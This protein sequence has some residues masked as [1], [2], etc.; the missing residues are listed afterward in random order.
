MRMAAA[1]EI[2]PGRRHRRDL[3][4]LEALADSI[5][6]R[7]LL[8]PIVITADNLLVC[9]ERRLRACR[10]VLGWERIPA[11]VMECET[12]AG[13]FHENEIR[14]QYTPS[15]RAALVE[16]LRSQGGAGARVEQAAM[17]AGFGSRRGYYRAA[18]VVE[19][20]AAELIEAMDSGA[21]TIAAAAQMASQPAGRQRELLRMEPG[22]RRKA[23]LAARRAPQRAAAA[24]EDKERPAPQAPSADGG[25]AG[26][27]DVA[28]RGP[29]RRLGGGGG[30]RPG[31]R[32]KARKAAA[33]LTSSIEALLAALDAADANPP[34]RR[35]GKKKRPAPGDERPVVVGPPAM[36]AEE[37][38]ARWDRLTDIQRARANAKARV[39][40]AAVDLHER[41]GAL[42]REAF[43]AAARGSDWSP[44][45]LR[46]WYYGSGGRAGLA[47][48]SRHLWPLALAPAHVGRVKRAECDPVAWQ[49]FLADY[50]RPEQPPLEMSYRT[51]KR[52]AG[53]EGWTIPGSSRA[54]KRRLEREVHPAAVVLARQ[55]P[56]AVARMRPA[57]IRARGSLRALEAVNADGHVFDVFVKWPD[58]KEARPVLVAWQDIHSG[59]ILSWRL[60]RTEN[61]DGY[62]LSFADLLREYGIPA[63]V[64]VDNGRGIASKMLTGGVH[65]RYRGKVKH[66]EPVGLLTQLVGA[67]N[68]HW[69]TPYSGQS[70]PIE[71]AFR[72]LA[73]DIAKDFRLRGAYTGNAPGAKPANHGEK[74]V[75]LER[76]VE[77]A[78][79]GIRQHNAR[80]GRRGLGLDGRSFDE[81][82]AASYE[83]HR[84]EIPRP[85][86][87]QIARWL[88]A[89]LA[90]TANKDTGAV[91]LYGNRY[92]SERLAETL[93]GKPAADRKVV[94]RF[95]PDRLDRPVTVETPEG[96][97][98]GKAEAQDA[99]P[100]MSTRAARETARDKAR[101]KRNAR[102][103]L[104][105]QQRMGERDLDKL[106]DAAAKETVEAGAPSGPEKMPVAAS[107]VVCGAF[108]RGPA[109]A[110]TG[111]PA[112]VEEIDPLVSRGDD[113]ILEAAAAE[114]PRED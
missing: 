19:R 62:R 13:Q 10:D 107:K 78:A 105:I 96:R 53:E 54:L 82:F 33:R 95:D 67:E 14:K 89:A 100:V 71:R 101:L 60:D 35:H 61:T 38:S 70:K 88:P 112:A 81:A 68:I 76:F 1:S 6:E 25:A 45:T 48:Y 50:L 17:Q 113:L 86:E 20:G 23:L 37:L 93:A 57:Q 59:K 84:A 97:L 21:V 16:A 87:A 64:F 73:T 79:D 99:A 83:A 15:E 110:A 11:R 2:V 104:E 4:D 41:D 44:A 3:G 43:T 85:T 80:R 39:I 52:L 18:Q 40:G 47:E 12:A 34:K 111:A 7:G 29:D 77:V 36:S 66:D 72:D 94:A 51:L 102:Q 108:G 5:R 92:W 75:E 28:V 109:R 32:A 46:N 103:A 65:W 91:Q 26:G 74:A 31:G 90:I 98:I 69:T 58:G 49:A 30:P 106:L 56:A 55:G 63:H 114:L 9:G 24:L 22:A 27:G 42:L 8:H